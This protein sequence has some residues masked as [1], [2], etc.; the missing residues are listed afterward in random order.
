MTEAQLQ[1]AVMA[2]L[3]LALPKD[4]VSFHPANEGRRSARAGADLKR[5]GM[6]PGLPDVMIIW[7]TQSYAIELKA[8][9]GRLSA[10]QAA[11]HRRLV[12]AGCPVSI[13]RSIDDV[14][15][16][17]TLWRFPLAARTAAPPAGRTVLEAG[18]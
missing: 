5:Q 16:F 7:R 9:N 2:Y 11:T 6:L 13:C 3:A 17:L 1:R 18:D 14:E 12:G 4:A 8:G 15:A 10:Q